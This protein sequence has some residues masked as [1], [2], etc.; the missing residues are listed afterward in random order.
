MDSNDSGESR[1][2]RF[3]AAALHGADSASATIRWWR[4]AL[5]SPVTLRTCPKY[6]ACSL[7]KPFSTLMV[8]SRRMI[9]LNLAYE[10]SEALA[11]VYD[12]LMERVD[13]DGWLHDVERLA[14]DYGLSGRRVL[15]IA[16]GTGRSAEPIV[17]R[18]YDVSA[19]DISPAMV[20]QAR[21][22]LASRGRHGRVDV[23]DMR[24]LPDWGRFDLI[25]CINDGL[26]NLLSIGELDAAFA[27]V[28]RSLEPGGLYI[29]DVT[30]LST[31]R[32][33]ASNPAMQHA[34]DVRFH[35]PGREPQ[36]SAICSWRQRMRSGDADVVV[37]AQ[38]HWPIALIRGHLAQ[39]GMRCLG[40]FALGPDVTRI[41]A[42]ESQ[43]RKVIFI[44]QLE[45]VEPRKKNGGSMY[46]GK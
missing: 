22:R 34:H 46:W 40:A 15:D 21:R 27:G 7:L 16:C 13:Y 14:V 1:R 29:F 37:Y 32:A 30:S 45:S 38:R 4:T 43:H 39:A 44:A 10:T 12:T 6:G 19:C 5:R 20:R 9:R 31:Y 23:A 28:A 11:P 17:A 33:F 42:D 35:L 3:M 8:L 36:P 26:N 24:D 2:F 18:D 25:T 41:E